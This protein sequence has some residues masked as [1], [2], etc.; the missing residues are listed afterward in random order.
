[1]QQ[2]ILKYLGYTAIFVLLFGGGFYFGFKTSDAQ[3][4]GLTATK[5]DIAAIANSTNTPTSKTLSEVAKEVDGVFFIQP[6]SKPE[7][8]E[9]HP[10]K[11]KYVNGSGIFY[12]TDN[13]N[14][15]KITPELCFAT[16][17]FAKT[18]GF[19]KKY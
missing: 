8:P 1:M 16:E 7:C 15:K 6:G 9:T 11:A 10:L 3:K 18:K 2:Q 19:I 12:N 4:S 5:A 14:Y 17:D 13:K